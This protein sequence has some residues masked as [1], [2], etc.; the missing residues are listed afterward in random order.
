[1]LEGLR[2]LRAR[3][4]ET[5]FVT[6]EGLNV[7]ALALYQSVGFRIINRDYDYVKRL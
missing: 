4:S 7:A 2:R 5:A 1:M 3:G 6:S